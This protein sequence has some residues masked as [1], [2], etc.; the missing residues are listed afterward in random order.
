[1]T[2]DAHVKTRRAVIFVIP[3]RESKK[4]RPVARYRQS[5]ADKNGRIGIVLCG[6]VNDS[7]VTP[8]IAE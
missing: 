8:V 2:L 7:E 5:Q 3:L 1:M 6:P 4:V